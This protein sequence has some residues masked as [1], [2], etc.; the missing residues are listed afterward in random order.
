[1]KKYLII[2]F[3]LI[4]SVCFAGSTISGVLVKGDNGATGATGATGSNGADGSGGNH[5][6]YYPSVVDFQSLFVIATTN[7][8]SETY[9]TQSQVLTRQ[10]IGF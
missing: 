2:L 1:M 10:S 3:C 4:H 9:P 6:G 8:H 7:Q 5:A